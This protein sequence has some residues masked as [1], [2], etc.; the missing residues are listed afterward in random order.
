LVTAG[1]RAETN[2]Q[3][4]QLLAFYRQVNATGYLQEGETLLAVT[5]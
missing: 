5:A 3:L 2:A 1:R 4:T